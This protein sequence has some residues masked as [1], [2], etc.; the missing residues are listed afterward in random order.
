MCIK[1]VVSQLVIFY[2]FRFGAWANSFLYIPDDGFF[3]FAV[4][5]ET[6]VQQNGVHPSLNLATEST[7]PDFVIVESDGQHAD[8]PVISEILETAIQKEEVKKSK[9]EKVHLFGKMFKKKAEPPADVKSV[10]EKETS[11]ED[12]M[13]VSLPATDPQPVSTLSFFKG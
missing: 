8:A 6:I 1:M 5:G 2:I 10:Q 12:Q 11:K 13:D 3:F 7:E 4:N 9:E